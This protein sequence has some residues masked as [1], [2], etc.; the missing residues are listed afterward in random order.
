MK[1]T[2]WITWA[3]ALVLSLVLIA[4]AGDPE[5][6]RAQQA[7]VEQE[8][9]P[10]QAP[11]AAEPPTEQQQPPAE[12]QQ[13]AEQQ[14][15]SLQQPESQEPTEPQTDQQQTLE[16]EPNLDQ[17]PTQQT[18]T[19]P[20]EAQQTEP[21]TEPLQIEPETAPERRP[22]AQSGTAQAGPGSAKKGHGAI[23]G[24]VVDAEDKQPLPN[25]RVGAYSIAAGD[26]E[27]TMAAG[28]ATSS[29]GN[30]RLSVPPGIYRVIV[31]LQS[32]DVTIRDDIAIAPESTVDIRIQLIPKPIQIKGVQVKGEQNKGTEAT[33]LQN[34]K[35]APVVS[36]AVTAEQMS[37]TTDSNAADALQRVTGLSVVDGKYVFVRGL[38]ERYSSTQVNGSTV[39]SPEPNRRVVPL[40]VFPAGV[41]DQVVVQKTYT[42]DQD[43]EFAGGVVNLSTKD[44]LEGRAYTQSV[45]IGYSS[46]AVRRSFLGYAGGK[47]DFLGFD[48]GTREL[49]ASIPT[50]Q[51]ATQSTLGG[52]GFT[53]EEL[54]AMGRSFSDT[55][56]GRKESAKP[57]Y[58]VAGSYA[59]GFKLFG[60]EAGFL[61]SLSL[62]NDFVSL[63]RQNNN[64]S[65]L[66]EQ[67]T[68]IYEYEVKE[69]IGKT[70]GGS[71]MNLSFR[72][73]QNGTLRLRGIYTRSSDDA[74]RI[75]E[76]PNYDY[77]TPG[78]R[79]E[80]LGYI[81]RGLFSG[82]ASGEHRFPGL[83]NVLA[84]W[85]VSY[86]EA[87]RNEPDRREN[88]YELDGTSGEYEMSRRTAYP[89]T[90]IFGDMEEFDRSYQVNLTL[91]FHTWGEQE[92]RFR[93][94]YALRDR[95]R[96]SA[97]RRFGFR[98]MQLGAQDL[99]T[100]MEP[101]SLLTDENIKPNYFMFS[102]QTR[103]ND[104][105]RAAQDLNAV[106]AMVDLPFL[107]PRFR[108]V[109][110]ARFEKS[111]QRVDTASP[112]GAGAPPVVA[113]LNTDDLLPSVNVTYAVTDRM[114]LRAGWSNTVSRPELR[115]L[116]PF[117]MYDYE[118]G[119]SEVGNP[120]LYRA[121][122]QSYDGR[123]ELFPD[124]R[125]LLALSVFHKSFDHPIE[126]VV[127]PG[128]GSYI[129]TPR[130]GEYG[131]LTGAEAEVR[132]GL[133]RP[134]SA[135]A[136]VISISE[137][138]SALKHFAL[139]ANY[140]RVTSKVAVR[141]STDNSGSP[142]LRVGP[143]G[144]QSSYALNLGLFY[145][146]R[147]LDGSVLY[148]AFGDRLAQFGAGQYPNSLPDVYEHP[149]KSLDLT[150]GKSISKD[151][152]LKFTAE[153]LLDE[154]VEF[155]QASEITRRYLP[156]RKMAIAVSFQ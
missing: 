102:E 60:R 106:Y 67:L 122:I 22:G 133:D 4:G 14:S 8:V 155:R 57:N 93:T 75:S 149:M 20:T 17:Q 3:C 50:D 95:N 45:S 79:I 111:D 31:S 151:V 52:P 71:L 51:R 56:Q 153:N 137:A 128:S 23:S 119:Y 48:D 115:E 127:L 37:K 154:A 118:T 136:S 28:V 76:G 112:Q 27:W 69:S 124:T 92:A 54:Q 109:G 83:A 114:N 63:E 123:W 89:F 98:L 74:T 152:R 42:P 87:D 7:P 80:H 100:S 36:D 126:N 2:H 99:D 91:P 145:A 138:P 43:A 68:P 21:Q 73:Y 29:E 143:L 134:W 65:G 142:I 90:R 26:S 72:P 30:F 9:A 130:N 103:D 107:S 97:Y 141:V 61:G 81:E 35:K 11:E 82:V 77:G 135:L 146:S 47:L 13:Q 46:N 129:L 64:Y 101:E 16:P 131:R 125:E 38:G 108:V 113:Q 41:L 55:W 58:S 88:V 25:A 144:G 94:G 86:S 1:R 32:Y 110:G 120:E 49:P 33:A 10:E 44:F 18:E 40:D 66:A 84:G 53:A 59:S 139:T 15:E 62:T 19:Q 78:V 121:K 140:S 105:Y 147:A 96:I 24:T 148:A 132:L 156:G 70:L 104:Q 117:D 5:T 34:Q 116:S 150:L 39:S 12:Q 85:T 6:G